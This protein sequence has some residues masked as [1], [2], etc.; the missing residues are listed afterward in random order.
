MT[1]KVKLHSRLE[2]DLKNQQQEQADKEAIRVFGANLKDLLL[3][4]P[5]GARVTMGLDPGLRTGVKVAVVDNTGK[6]LETAT[7]YPHVPHKKWNE[8][9]AQ[10][11]VMAKRHERLYLLQEVANFQIGKFDFN[12]YEDRIYSP[13]S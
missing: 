11:A 1:W 3:A 10:L 13:N 2:L 8:S 4:A 5:A 9:L 6:L 7:I 12:R